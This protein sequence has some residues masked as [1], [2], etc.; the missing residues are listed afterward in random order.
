MKK[1]FI[2]AIAVVILMAAQAKAATVNLIGYYDSRDMESVTLKVYG[3]LSGKVG[4][5]GFIDMFTPRGELED[6]DNEADFV[7]YYGEGNI[8]YS[9]TPNWQT[10]LEVNDGNLAPAVLRPQICYWLPVDSQG[11]NGRIGIKFNPYRFFLQE[12]DPDPDPEGQ[13]VLVWRFNFLEDK[14]FFEGVADINWAWENQDNFYP[15]FTEPQLGVNLS[16]NTSLLVEYRYN[17]LNRL[18]QEPDQGWAFGL[19]VRF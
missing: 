9:I 15:F 10:A 8:S 11:F 5:W 12:K 4:A 17:N 19:E 3:P 13:V 18:I 1:V 16:E 7:L 14:I 6:V 2:A